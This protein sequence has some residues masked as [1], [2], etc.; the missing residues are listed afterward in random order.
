[1]GLAL[2]FWHLIQDESFRFVLDDEANGITQCFTALICTAIVF[3]HLAE[4]L[5][6]WP[7]HVKVDLAVC[8]EN[9]V[10]RVR[11]PNCR[12]I[13]DLDC[14]GLGL[15]PEECPQMRNCFWQIA[16]LQ[17]KRYGPF[18]KQQITADLALQAADC[19][20]GRDKACPKPSAILDDVERD[21][22]RRCRRCRLR[23]CSERNTETKGCIDSE[24]ASV[25]MKLQMDYKWKY[26]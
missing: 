15:V 13:D 20:L 3:A 16:A 10:A 2:D 18:P 6:V 22:Y 14:R 19:P 26:T 4:W 24:M 23:A 7:C 11:C 17:L 8:P 9:F 1:M 25:N 21:I 12:V 5:A